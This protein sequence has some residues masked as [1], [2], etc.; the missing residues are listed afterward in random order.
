[1]K[2]T[3]ARLQKIINNKNNRQTQKRLSHIREKCFTNTKRNRQHMNLKNNTVKKWT[4]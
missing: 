2:M 1:M 4:I 3:K